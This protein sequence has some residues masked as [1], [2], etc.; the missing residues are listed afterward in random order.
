MRLYN[1]NLIIV[2]DRLSLVDKSIEDIKEI[3]FGV[4]KKILALRGDTAHPLA[5]YTF[6]KKYEFSRKFELAKYMMRNKVDTDREKALIAEIR[7]LDIV[8]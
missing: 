2:Q 6:D 4:T 7:R 1:S 8:K 5:N 3:Y